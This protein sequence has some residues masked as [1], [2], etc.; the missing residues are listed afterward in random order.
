MSAEIVCI[1]HHKVLSWEMYRG[2]LFR[3]KAVIQ[4]PLFHNEAICFYFFSKKVI[5]KIFY[6]FRFFSQI[7]L[8]KHQFQQFFFYK[9]SDGVCVF[10]WH[11]RH[12]LS[13]RPAIKSLLYFACFSWLITTFSK[14]HFSKK[15]TT[16]SNNKTRTI[17]NKKYGEKFCVPVRCLSVARSHN[18]HV[19]SEWVDLIACITNGLY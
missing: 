13:D 11:Q 2:K 17:P 5:S 18:R 6:L 10:I 14:N 1:S 8:I 16:F 4:L 15:K 12:H 3:K 9:R 7:F 19:C